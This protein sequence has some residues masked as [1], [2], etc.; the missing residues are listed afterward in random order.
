MAG[1]QAKAQV[2]TRQDKVMFRYESEDAGGFIELDHRMSREVLVARLRQTSG[3]TSVT[4]C[5]SK[6]NQG[7][8]KGEINAPD[9]GATGH[10]LQAN[11]R[12]FSHLS[13]DRFIEF[14]LT[15][16][17]HKSGAIGHAHQAT[18]SM[19]FKK[20]SRMLHL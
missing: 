12:V 16:N 19:V 15:R 3:V 13:T 14:E 5:L 18:V 20:P 9:Y 17:H 7:Q 4:D 6:W 1:P 2:S 10:Y 8:N 11:V